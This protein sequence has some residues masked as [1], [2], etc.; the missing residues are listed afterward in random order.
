[1]NYFEK[2]IKDLTDSKSKKAG[3]LYSFL[4]ILLFLAAWEI[5]VGIIIKTNSF[6]QFTGFLPSKT[7]IALIHLLTSKYF[8]DSV[9]ASLIR[10]LLGLFISSVIG[11]PAGLII[12]F[13]RIFR[14]ITNIP[15]Q[16]LRMISP[17][18]W[19]PI[20][21]VILPGFQEAILF[22]IAIS[23]IWP[24]LLNTSQGV[25]NIELQWITMAKNQG[26]KDYQLLFKVIFPG[27]MPYILTGLRF[28]IGVAWIV[29]VPAELLGISSGLGYLIND[30][31]DTMEY[32]KLM[33]I[34]VAIGL[35]GFTIDE[36]FQS[37]QKRLDWR[38]KT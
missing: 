38:T 31:R 37:I 17:L 23:C 26:A 29:L 21:I 12:G 3:V 34:V 13:Y 2:I 20:A 10:I 4:G 8:W 1:M 33:A 15:I 32:D 5:F 35:I 24:I 7:F 19:M 25:L 36:F 14:R 6:K 22:I 9:V 16:F 11:I 27:A 18:A 30:A 28:A